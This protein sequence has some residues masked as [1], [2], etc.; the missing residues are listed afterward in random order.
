MLNS[1]VTI[2]CIT[3]IAFILFGFQKSLKIWTKAQQKGLPRDPSGDHGGYI[4]L[5][6][7]ILKNQ[8]QPALSLTVRILHLVWIKLSFQIFGVHADLPMGKEYVVEVTPEQ[9]G[10]LVCMWYEY[11]CTAR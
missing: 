7:I 11:R 2:I 4:R 1:I 10:E 6:L 3:L 5:E 8:C 9:A